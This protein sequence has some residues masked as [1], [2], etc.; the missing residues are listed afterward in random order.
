MSTARKPICDLGPEF[1]RRLDRE[2]Q[3]FTRRM[4]EIG[5]GADRFDRAEQIQA[6]ADRLLMLSDEEAG[7]VHAS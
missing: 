2:V 1:T 7:H 6:E 5:R 3:R 4:F